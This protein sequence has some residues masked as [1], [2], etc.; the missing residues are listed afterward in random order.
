MNSILVGYPFLIISIALILV[1]S[2]AWLACPA[3]RPMIWRSALLS[4]PFGLTSVVFVPEYWQPVRVAE[5]IC[6]PED[7][8]FSLANGG[9]VWA[10]AMWFK[11]NQKW[12]WI[13]WEQALKRYFVVVAVCWT[14]SSSLW[15]LGLAVMPA[16]LISIYGLAGYVL[17]QYPRLLVPALRAGLIFGLLYSLILTG[18]MAMWPHFLDQWNLTV[19]S[20]IKVG[21]VPVEELV[22]AAGF[23]ISWPLFMT[24]V[25]KASPLEESLV[26]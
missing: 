5:F 8:I 23:G 1:F 10:A 19:R 21:L 13:S 17:W 20:G 7:I 16:V 15:L 24:Y 18:G 26:R 11:R 12:Q 25:F 2:L 9:I 3:M 4:A 14:F 22:W 6:G